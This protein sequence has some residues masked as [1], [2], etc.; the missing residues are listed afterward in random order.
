[1]VPVI[2]YTRDGCPY[3]TKAVTLLKSKGAKFT[4][5]NNSKDGSYRAEMIEKSG[6][7]TFPQVFIGSTHVGGC[8]DVHA[9]DASGKLDNMLSGKAA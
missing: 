6:R 1:M 8:D 5:Y 4:E 7:T 9:L 2:I 3:C